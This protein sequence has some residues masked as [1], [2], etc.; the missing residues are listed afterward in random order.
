VHDTV[1]G[2]S[3]PEDPTSGRRVR[4]GTLP[5]VQ[6][7]ELAD[8]TLMFEGL[9]SEVFNSNGSHRFLPARLTI[10]TNE[11]RKGNLLVMFSPVGGQKIGLKI[12]SEQRP[13]FEEFVAA[14][15]PS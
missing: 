12:T 9:V 8:A 4:I 2:R 6:T 15:R 5:K 11:D 3:G 7:L 10:D 1:A 14:I 13:A